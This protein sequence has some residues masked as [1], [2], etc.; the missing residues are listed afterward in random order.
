MAHGIRKTTAEF[1][2]EAKNIHGDKYDYSL[3]QYHNAKTKVKI[4]CPVHGVFEQQPDK[5]INGKSGCG[6]CHLEN[7]RMDHDDFIKQVN[8][9]HNNKYDYSQTKYVTSR[10]EIKII[11]PTHGEFKTKPNWHLN[12]RGC[13]ICNT[14]KGEIKI[15]KYLSEN[16]LDFIQQHKFDDCVNKNK[17]PFDFYLP[18]L[19]L[20]IE[21]DG[22]QHFEPIE[23]FGGLKHLKE[24]QHNDRIKNKYCEDKNIKLIRIRYDENVTEKLKASIY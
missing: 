24:T 1:I 21:F 18:K 22:K 11:C 9:I 8:I 17:L 15:N 3:A 10:T 6:K 14:S 13:P 20:L 12:G 16:G 2:D 5:H 4:I 23:F 19:N 7:S